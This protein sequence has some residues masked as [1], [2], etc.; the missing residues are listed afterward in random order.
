[1]R[2]AGV[3]SVRL[4]SACA[5]ALVLIAGGVASG[6]DYWVSVAGNDGGAGTT[7]KPFAPTAHGKVMRADLKALG[8]TDYG[9]LTRRGGIE[10]RILPSALELFFNDRP[11]PLARWPNDGHAHIAAV[12][13]GPA[14]ERFVYEGDRP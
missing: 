14:G 8:I 2:K 11:M 1:M 7:D 9:R 4:V 12:P 6:R 3:M 5:V 10:R 13:S